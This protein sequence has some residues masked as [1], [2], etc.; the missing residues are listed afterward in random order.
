MKTIA[1]TA[2]LCTALLGTAACGE[3]DAAAGSIPPPS[4]TTTTTT[5]TSTTTDASAP[6]GTI[7]IEA[8]DYR[9]EDL[10]ATIPAGTTLRLTNSSTVELHELVA[11]RLP[12]AETRPVEELIGL[13]RAE[14]EQIVGGPPAAVLVAPPASDGFPVVGDGV[15]TEPGRYLLLCAIPTG[16]DPDEYL[17]ATAAGGGPP[18]GQ[19]GGPPH[20]MAGMYAEIE[21]LAQG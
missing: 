11:L 16:V 19:A 14:L 15:L 13:P 1:T 18:S 2:L 9:F 4:T 10:P 12:D 5:T 17:A 8:V 20:L 3:D 6:D 21:V 7:T